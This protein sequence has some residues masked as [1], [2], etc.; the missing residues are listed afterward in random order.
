V[1]AAVSLLSTRVA[2]GG[3]VPE[4]VASALGQQSLRYRVSARRSYFDVL[5][6]P[7]FDFPYHLTDLQM[8]MEG[9]TEGGDR[10]TFTGYTGRD[11][12]DL[13][14]VESDFPLRIDWDWGNDAVGFGWTRPRRGGG[15]LDVRTNFSRFKTGLVFPDFGDT[16]FRSRIQQAQIRAD[17][18]MRPTPRW[19]V[20]VGG[21][22][23]RL[24]YKNSFITGGTEFGG[25]LGDGWLLGGYAQARYTLP[26]AWVVEVGLRA[27]GFRP[28]PGEP[29]MEISPRLAVK[30]FV[31]GGDIAFKLA[32]G[33]YTQFIHSMRDEELPLGL[34]IWVIAGER[35][36]HTVSDQIQF[37]IEGYRDIDWFWSAEAYYRRF[38]GVVSLNP[39]DN[40]N[41]PLDDILSGRGVS[42]GADFLLRKETGAVNG[43]VAVSYLKAERTF[44]D[45]LSPLNPA[46]EITFAPIFDRRVDVDFVLR[47]PAPFGWEGGLRWN[48]GTGIPFTRALGSYSYYTPRYV[49]GGGLDWTGSEDD[50]ESQGGYGV[51]VG[52]RNASRYPN[53]HR[54]D[55]SFRR[56]FPKTWGSL[57]PYVNLVNVYNQR[58]VLFYFYEYNLVPPTRSG[59]SMFPVLPTIGLEISF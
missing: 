36:P 9:W 56:S 24:S 35:A 58:N 2:V 38:E 48:F 50:L 51:V 57:T 4:G 29:V 17:L 19:A 45:P 6:K 14:S 40:P 12:F 1:D 54:L 13:A 46:P 31:N 37:G 41:D 16:D 21:A 22:T 18:D 39:A 25:G 34:D 30:R 49:E 59:I 7:A 43:W 20:Q 8:F 5:F 15:S 3:R 55:V 23:E 32:A 52:D 26:R 33:R 10:L 28:D 53:Y 11:V 27:D 47:Y 44:P 42:W